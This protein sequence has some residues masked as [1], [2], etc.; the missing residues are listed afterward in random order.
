[1]IYIYKRMED[2]KIKFFIYNLF[3][4]V[5][6][7]I[8]PV[9]NKYNF[10]IG[11]SHGS[12]NYLCRILTRIAS[13]VS[14]SRNYKIES[15]HTLVPRVRCFANAIEIFGLQAQLFHWNK[16]VVNGDTLHQ[17]Y[18]SWT[19]LR[20]QYVYITVVTIVWW[21]GFRIHD[22]FFFSPSPIRKNELRS[23]INRDQNILSH[24]NNLL[25][26]KII[27]EPI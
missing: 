10:I 5:K 3:W 12:L 7:I 23:T 16:V 26:K 22:C 2:G 14:I 17:Y 6:L 1:M 11:L 8:L 19:G 27:D 13:R 24:D 4:I 21:N 20:Q 18:S 25:K 9:S 15:T